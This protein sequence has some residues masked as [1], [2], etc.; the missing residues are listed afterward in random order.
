M[1]QAEQLVAALRRALRARGITHRQLAGALRV[2]EPTVK[3]MFSGRA[4]TLDR[5]EAACGLAGVDLYELARMAGR[6]AALPRELTPEQEE[7]LARD[8]RLLTV[9]HLLLSEWTAAEILADYALAEAELVRLLARL[10]RLGLIELAPGNRVRLRC[11]RHVDWRRDGPVRRAYAERVLREF[12]PPGDA[13]AAADLRF[14]VRELSAA[15]L[16]AMRRRLDRL[17][18]EFNELAELDG[19]LPR[20][21]RVS[22]GLALA[23]RPWVLSATAA[24][25]RRPLAPP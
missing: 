22:V 5:L 7:A 14:E 4:V 23:C 21:E 16:A 3:R 13:G 18:A 11:A 25:R 20:R 19:T 15:S 8:A 9:F 1:A 2:S 10:E 12:L 24:L 6:E 17:A